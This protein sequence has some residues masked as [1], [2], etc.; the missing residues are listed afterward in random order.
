[1]LLDGLNTGWRATETTLRG[2]RTGYR[3]LMG[4]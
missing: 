2:F 4:F 3:H 1:M